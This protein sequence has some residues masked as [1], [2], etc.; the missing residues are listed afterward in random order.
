M[1]TLLEV[2]PE[3]RRGVEA[4]PFRERSPTNHCT[5]SLK[6]HRGEEKLGE[7]QSRHIYDVISIHE[8]FPGFIKDHELDR[9]PGDTRERVS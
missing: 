3:R 4:D 5:S 1:V 9:V 2:M 8:K 7:R 6:T